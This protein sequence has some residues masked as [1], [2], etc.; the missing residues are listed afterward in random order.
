MIRLFTDTSANLPYKFIERYRITV[1]PFSYTVNGK[2]VDYPKDRDFDGKAF[3][4]AMRNGDEIKTSMVNESLFLQAFEA[5]VKEGDSVL[6]VG[7][8]GGISGTAGSAKSAAAELQERYPK[9]QIAVIDTLAA[10]L[11]EGLQVLDAAALIEKGKDFL[12]IADKIAEG[13]KRMHQFFTV[14][15]LNYLKKGGRLSSAAAFVGNIL[16][17]KPILMGNEDGKIVLCGKTRGFK[18]AL[19]ILAEK[20]A[21]MATDKNAPVG[22][23]HADN[24]E[25]LSYLMEKLKEKAFT[26]ELLP[27]VYEPV[28][29]SHVGPGTVALFFYGD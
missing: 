12:S 28:T 13:R 3:Y 24:E 11:G 18:K 10:S 25:G 6:Y 1:L 22:I 21:K 9:A 19:D 16:N 7:M 15:D 29:G 2:A 20:F 23:A 14:E 27:V 5:C 26:G 17:I 4:D 8:S